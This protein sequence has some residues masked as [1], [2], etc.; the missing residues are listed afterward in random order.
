VGAGVE[1]CCWMPAVGRWAP[2]TYNLQP[3]ASSISFRA[4][5]AYFSAVTARPPS[6]GVV[7]G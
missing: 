5:L 3:R 6:R 4:A 7:P 1:S 2:D